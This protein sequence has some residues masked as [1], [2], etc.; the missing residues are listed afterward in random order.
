MF[1]V[2]VTMENLHLKN[3]DLNKITKYKKQTTVLKN[4]ELKNSTKN[5]KE[6]LRNKIIRLINKL[7]T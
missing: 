5:Q 2:A 1:Y 6:P 7:P 4:V 3:L